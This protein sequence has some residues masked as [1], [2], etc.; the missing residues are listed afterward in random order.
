[1]GK[2]LDNH[3]ALVTGGTRGIGRAIALRLAKEGAGVAI[4]GLAKGPH[5]S[6]VLEEIDQ[7]KVPSMALRADQALLSGREHHRLGRP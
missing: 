1:M 6:E 4:V 3:L 2:R 5:A 7:F